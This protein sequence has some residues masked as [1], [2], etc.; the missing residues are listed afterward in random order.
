[1]SEPNRCKWA[2]SPEE[3]EYHDNEWGV[4]EFEDQKLYEFLLLE[5]FQAGLSWLTILKKR[6]A[7]RK[8]FDEF[9]YHTIA[10]YNSTKVNELLH[11]AQIIRNKR[12]IEAAIANAKA[13]QK[14]QE[15][16]GSFSSFFWSYTNHTPIINSWQKSS[17]VP[18]KTPLSE[19][20]SRDMKKRGFTF[21]GPTI[22]YSLMQAVGMVND[23]EINCFRYKEVQT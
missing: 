15:E 11:S 18:A 23:H 14:V 6:E 22:C 12:K 10:R 16:F 8:A 13:F 19:K 1:M 4:P 9:D 7:F 3:K 5:S 17:E 20:I 21:F 2:K